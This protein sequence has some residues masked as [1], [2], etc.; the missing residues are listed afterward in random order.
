M[1]A[2]SSTVTLPALAWAPKV[3]VR[4]THAGTS[5]F[6]SAGTVTLG[7]LWWWN[8]REVLVR[9]LGTMAP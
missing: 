7:Y 4:S 9:I 3:L 6:V 8:R 1:P 2:G 5:A